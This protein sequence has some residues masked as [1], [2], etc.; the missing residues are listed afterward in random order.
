MKVTHHS[1]PHVSH[2]ARAH[3]SPLGGVHNAPQMPAQGAAPGAPTAP[4]GNLAIP[5][6]MIAQATGQAP[7]QP[8]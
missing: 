3:E 5:P 8:Q 4:G 1:P 6:E 7:P 2:S